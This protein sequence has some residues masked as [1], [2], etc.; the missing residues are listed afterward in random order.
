M[1]NENKILKQNY[2]MLERRMRAESRTSSQ[3]SLPTLPDEDPVYEIPPNSERCLTESKHSASK[4]L[5]S[6]I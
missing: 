2:T 4:F 5:Q 1:E 6:L 3:Q